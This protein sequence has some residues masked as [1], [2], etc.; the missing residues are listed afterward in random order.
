[1]TLNTVSKGECDC[2]PKV[3]CTVFTVNGMKMCDDCKAKNDAAVAQAVEVNS[4]LSQSRAVDASIQIKVDIFQAATTSAIELKGAIDHDEN[5]PAE[6]KDYVMAQESLKRFQHLQKVIFDAR[7]ELLN[8]ENELRAWQTQVQQFAGK[9]RAEQKEQFRNFDI[10][11]QPVPVKS[12]KPTTAKASNKPK[13]NDIKEMAAK[14]GVPA[15]GVSMIAAA[16]HL[17]A[18]GAAK[19][20][21]ETMSKKTETK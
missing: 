14:Y 19:Y 16:R 3:D 6:Q 17:S 5:I 1:M 21:A 7:Q 18:E 2:C 13:L 4:M 11:Y 10:S 8:R 15:A 9:L 20:L 12:V